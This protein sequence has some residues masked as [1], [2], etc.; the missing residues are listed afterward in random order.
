VLVRAGILRSHN[1][2]NEDS[3]RTNS[4]AL[5]SIFANPLKPEIILLDIGLPG[6]DGYEVARMLRQEDCCRDALM[7]AESGYGQDEDLRRSKESGFDHHLVKPVDYNAL[8]AILATE[9]G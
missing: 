9:Y 4:D 1:H 6:I 7:I 2:F 5:R 8:M 3:R